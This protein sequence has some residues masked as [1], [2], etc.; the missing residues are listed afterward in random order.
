MN[1]EKSDCFVTRMNKT[2]DPS[3]FPELKYTI[4]LSKISFWQKILSLNEEV[5]IVLQSVEQ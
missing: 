5:I 3:R 1:L 4:L 2:M